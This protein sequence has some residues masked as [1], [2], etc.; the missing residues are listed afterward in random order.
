MY[1]EQART[2]NPKD[3]QVQGLTDFGMSDHGQVRK[4]V[5][6]IAPILCKS[7]YIAL[8]SIPMISAPVQFILLPRCWLHIWM[9]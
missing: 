8:K 5:C 1:D 7:R 6:I 2:N 3:E 4:V 9:L